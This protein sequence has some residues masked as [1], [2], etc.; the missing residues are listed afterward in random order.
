MRARPQ[1]W[2]FWSHASLIP[3]ARKSSPTSF[4]TRLESLPSRILDDRGHAAETCARMKIG[5]RIRAGGPLLQRSYVM[6]FN[7]FVIVVSQEY[8]EALIRSFLCV[9]AKWEVSYA[10]DCR[11]S[12]PG[13]LP[14]S[15]AGS[16]SD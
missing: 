5:W 11:R 12:S 4:P 15:G 16:P 1:S 9:L 2:A 6:L 13:Q 14:R 10:T 8:N 7:P 3:R